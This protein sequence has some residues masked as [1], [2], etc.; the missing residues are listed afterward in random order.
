VTHAV[1][2]DA[3]DEDALRSI[4]VGD[5]DVAIVAISSATDASIFATMAL[6][7]LGVS[8]VVAKAAT[9]LHGAILERIGADRVIYAEAE[10]GHRVAH[11]LSISGALEYLDLAPDFGV[12]KLRPPA[13][14]VGQ[15][16]AALDLGRLEIAAVALR[17]GN[18]VTVNP[19]QDA[20]LAADD[21]V[22][23]L[24]RDEQLQRIGR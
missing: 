2:L 20:V 10:M 22:T 4:G 11:S 3:A 13:S 5:F 21:E 14:W 19:P 7:N 8:Q 18:A 23:L 9:K 16:L 12:V 17:R 6:K 15:S 24:G 1:Q